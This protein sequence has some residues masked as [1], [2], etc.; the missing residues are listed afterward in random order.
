V[1]PMRE[2]AGADLLKLTRFQELMPEVRDEE[3]IKRI[4]ALRD[5]AI[6]G[7]KSLYCPWNLMKEGTDDP[8]YYS[9][10]TASLSA[11]V[12]PQI[13][14]M[15]R[16]PR[17]LKAVE[18]ETRE[19][20][21]G[22]LKG[23]IS[24]Y[25]LLLMSALKVGEQGVFEWIMREREVFMDEEIHITEPTDA[26][27]EEARSTIEE[28]LK[29]LLEVKTKA[30]FELIQK[31]VNELFPNFMKGLGGLAQ[32]I[33][34]REPQ[35]WMQRI[36]LKPR[37]GT[38]YF[39]RYSAGSIPSTEAPDQ[40]TLQY[41]RDIGKNGFEQREFEQRYL[42]SQRKLTNDINKFVQFSSLLSKK[43]ALQVCD[44][45]LDWM[46]DREHWGVWEQE[47]E[48]VSALMVDVKL[49]T[50]NAG[51]FEFAKARRKA[52]QGDIK[53][54]N[55][56]EWSAEK[57]KELA[58][59]DIIVAIMYAR[60]VGKEILGEAKTEEILGVDLKEKFLSKKEAIWEKAKGARYYLSW[61]L[62]V[63]KYNDDY[64][65]IRKQV[66]ESILKIA[67]ADKSGEI[68]GSVVISLVNYQYPAGRPDL[69]EGYEFGVNKAENQKTFN[70]DMLLSLIAEWKE[71][72]FEDAVA[73][74]A[75][76]FLIKEYAEEL[77]EL[78]EK[79]NTKPEK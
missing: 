33:T 77:K 60:Y 48:Y 47:E 37:Y 3:V 29:E 70:M 62:G 28:K 15:I 19:K 42:N 50:D 16:T 55:L 69:I 13:T 73:A 75:Y 39:E 24:W 34:S 35:D 72:K 8:L 38:S 32:R 10:L 9:S 53:E 61:L 74:K 6:T 65:S 44:C 23:E 71:R 2:G 21:N 27:K 67:K 40:P 17:H 1:G 66:T 54:A 57:L 76:E 18:R 11:N 14:K 41:I 26:E 56:E 36:A 78:G 46:C 25:D 49:I 79:K 63:L 20:W 52:R 4:K 64:G 43:L 30:R 22:G 45:M 12:G 31:V 59:K 7:E 5:E 68:A 58:S 51:Q